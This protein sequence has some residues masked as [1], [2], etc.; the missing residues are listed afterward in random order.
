MVK[1]EICGHEGAWEEFVGW[2]GK[3]VC[4]AC[5]EVLKEEWIRKK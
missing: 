3:R 1:C 2:L 4:K 5:K